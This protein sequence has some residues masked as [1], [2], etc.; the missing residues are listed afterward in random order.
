MQR[1]RSEYPL[2][3]LELR[4]AG[5]EPPAVYRNC[6]A[7]SA[8]IARPIAGRLAKKSGFHG[9]QFS[10]IADLSREHPSLEWNGT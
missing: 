9:V 8:I 3:R 10:W 4:G 5:A 7:G 2:A 6:K 1:R